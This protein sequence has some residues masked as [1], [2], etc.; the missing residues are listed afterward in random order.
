MKKRQ[1]EPFYIKEF[2]LIQLRTNQAKTNSHTKRI[3][4][5]IKNV[6]QICIKLVTQI[7]FKNDLNSLIYH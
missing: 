5:Q 3:N 4:S 1:F 2:S 7:T 6:K